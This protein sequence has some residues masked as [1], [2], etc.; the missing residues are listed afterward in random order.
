MLLTDIRNRQYCKTLILA[1][2]NFGGSGY[3]IIFVAIIL[4]FLFAELIR[5]T[6]IFSKQL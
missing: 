5:G 2:L 6:L 4:A 1:A 3:L